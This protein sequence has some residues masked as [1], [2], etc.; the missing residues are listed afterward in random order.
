MRETLDVHYNEDKT[1]ILA[2]RFIIQGYEV[3]NIDEDFEMIRSL[4]E[5]ADT[6]QFEVLTYHPTFVYY[7]QVRNDYNWCDIH[8]MHLQ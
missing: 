8:I 1:R 6:S 7:D 2:A 4:R 5:L 3:H